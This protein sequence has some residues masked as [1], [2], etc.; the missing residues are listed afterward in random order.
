M[1][2]TRLPTGRWNSGEPTVLASATRYF[3]LVGLVIGLL[4]SML[5]VL[6]SAIMPTAVVLV[7]MLIAAVL[8]TGALH[9]DG[10]ADVADSAGVFG[11][12]RK[13]DIMRDSRIGTYGA[14]ALILLV[15]LK[16]SVLW[17]L[18]VHASNLMVV[19][20]ISAYVLARWSSCWL[21]YRLP[22]VRA[23]A[24]NRVVADGMNGER[25]LFATSISVVCLLPAVLLSGPLVLLLLPLAWLVASL[26]GLAFR[27][28]YG[29]ITGDC[30]GAA[31]QLVEVSVML[32]AVAVPA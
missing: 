15:A 6:L 26:C 30:L 7:L 11:V 21:M 18:S 1:F 10:L 2:L 13:L 12:A 20:L 27:R 14:L 32:A 25:L 8:I 24:A 28:W 16:F 17:S 3:P 22:Y 19:T 23:D 9:E 31:N 29:G 5:Y 4:L